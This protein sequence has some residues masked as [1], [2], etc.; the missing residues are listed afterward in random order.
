MTHNHPTDDRSQIIRGLHSLAEFLADRPEIPVPLSID[1][2]VSVLPG[3]DRERQAEVLRIA[4]VLGTSVD[5]EAMTYGHHRASVSF[6][7]VTYRAVAVTDSARAQWDALM[8][9]DNAVIP[10]APKGA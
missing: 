5:A 9:Y 8:S 10:D 2:I 4:R 3:S 7:P 1:I 6:G